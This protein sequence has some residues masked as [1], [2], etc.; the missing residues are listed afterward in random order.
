MAER[1]SQHRLERRIARAAKRK[2]WREVKY[3]MA[4]AGAVF[5]NPRETLLLAE[6]SQPPCSR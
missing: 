4:A 2:K 5:V 1:E 3:L 6:V